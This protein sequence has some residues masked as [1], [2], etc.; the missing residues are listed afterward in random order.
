[1]NLAVVAV[2]LGDACPG[3][4]E[5]VHYGDVGLQRIRVEPVYAGLA[6]NLRGDHDGHGGA[7]VSLDVKVGGDI[8]L[9]GT[10]LKNHLCAE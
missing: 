4:H 6:E 1:M 8:L 2:Q 3:G 9:T 5:Y 10:H 7:P